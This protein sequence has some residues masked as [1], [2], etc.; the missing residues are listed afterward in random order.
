MGPK[1]EVDDILSR[2]DRMHE[3]DRRS[4]GRTMGHSKDRTYA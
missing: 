3:R 4:D 1:K 2:L